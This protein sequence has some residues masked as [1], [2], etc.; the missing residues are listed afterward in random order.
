VE[1]SGRVKPGKIWGNSSVTRII[2]EMQEKSL[3]LERSK[4]F[5][6]FCICFIKIIS[7]FFKWGI[8]NSGQGNFK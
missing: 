1:K 7:I 2:F 4:I 3:I 6:G 5:K 8:P